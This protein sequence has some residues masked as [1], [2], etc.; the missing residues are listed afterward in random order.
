MSDTSKSVNTIGTNTG[1]VQLLSP[2]RPRNIAD[3][4]CSFENLS[5][6]Y[7][8]GTEALRNINL[9]IHKG[10]FVSVI[11]PSGCGKSTLARIASGLL[12]QTDGTLRID[13]EHLAFTFQEATLL[14]WRKVLGNVELLMELKN[15]PASE[16]RR[17]AL[18]QIEMV[19]LKGFEDR[20]P[21]ALSGG[22]R[23]R[24]SL[25]RSFA[26]DPDVFLFDEPFGALDEI[27]RERLIEELSALH[28][29]NGFTGM[30]I[31]HSIPEA[32]YLSTRVVVMSARPGEIAAEYAINLPQP[33][34]AD[35][36]FDPLF[37]QGCA[38]LSH[39]LRTVIED[40][41]AGDQK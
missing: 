15:L 1:G 30:F 14:P 13:R 8:D 4:A 12:T 32:I 41:A 26:L 9:D 6:V 20:Y 10:E 25:A 19:G 7:P 23:M 21:R 36:R 33:R 16:R 29:A 27:T 38:E 18:E 5:M 39:K 24:A 40:A 3:I 22:M 17:K 2:D 28:R 37:T 11:G 35:M 34:T 31:T